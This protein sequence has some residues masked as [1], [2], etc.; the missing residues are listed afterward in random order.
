MNYDE[1]EDVNRQQPRI[2]THLLEYVDLQR[3]E[4]DT[5]TT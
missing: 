4:V 1:H 2:L 5:Q 3:G